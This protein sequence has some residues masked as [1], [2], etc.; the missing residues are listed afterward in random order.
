MLQVNLED[1]RKDISRFIQG[2]ECGE[3][4]IITSSGKPVA[5]VNP[6]TIKSPEMRPYALCAGEFKVPDDFDDPLPNDILES[7]EG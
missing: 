6:I 4:L 2:V 5:E 7:F 3:K 1:I